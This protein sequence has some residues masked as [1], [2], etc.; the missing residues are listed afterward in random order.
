PSN[1]VSICAAHHLRGIHGGLLRVTGSAPDGLVW[2][3]G[4]KRSYL[5]AD[6]CR[7]PELATAAVLH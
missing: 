3:F 5:P 2:E 7:R 6:C 4:L 1:L